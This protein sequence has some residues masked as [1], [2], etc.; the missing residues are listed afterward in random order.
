MRMMTATSSADMMRV[1]TQVRHVSAVTC[2]GS[3]TSP[4]EGVL[5]QFL[6]YPLRK[7]L[8]D[9]PVPRNWL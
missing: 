5:G 2:S 7:Y 4:F 1:E 9:F 8:I 6:D 3:F